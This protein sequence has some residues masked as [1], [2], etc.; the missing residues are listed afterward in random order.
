M[1]TLV[2]SACSWWQIRMRGTPPL[3]SGRACSGPTVSPPCMRQRVR[4]Q[5]ALPHCIASM[6]AAARGRA[7]TH[8]RAHVLCSDIRVIIFAV[9]VGRSSMTLLSTRTSHVSAVA[10]ASVG[11]ITCTRSGPPGTAALPD[12]LGPHLRWS[13]TRTPTPH[14]SAPC[15][16]ARS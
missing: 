15:S 8:T 16:P 13:A 3:P 4:A 12:Q 2:F 10:N 14:G 6:H 5:P 7:R 1:H 11:S 9:T